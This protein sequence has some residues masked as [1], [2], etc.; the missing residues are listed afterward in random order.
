MTDELANWETINSNLSGQLQF[1]R[2]SCA[3][4]FENFMQVQ[5]YLRLIIIIIIIIFF[6]NNNIIYLRISN[7]HHFQG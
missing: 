6:N 4:L 2:F 7:Q 5:D 1:F 3:L